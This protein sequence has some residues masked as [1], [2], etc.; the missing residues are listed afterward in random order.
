MNAEEI[1]SLRGL[2]ATVVLTGSVM[3][4]FSQC[5]EDMRAWCVT[6]GFINVEWLNF[7]AQ[8]VEVG[9]DQVIAH[10]AE[11]K[12]NFAL[13]IDAD[14]TFKPELLAQMLQSAFDTVPDSD[15]LG[16]Y[17]QLKHSPFLPVIDTGTGT[18]EAHFPG[19][20]ILSCIRTGGHCV[21][22]KT[23]AWEKFGPPW[24]RTRNTLRPL[25]V[26]KELDNFARV[27]NHGVNPFA[28]KDW[29]KLLDETTRTQGGVISG[30]GEDSGFC[31]ALLAAGG[32]LYVD[33][34]IVTGHIRKVNTSPDDLRDAMRA[35]SRLLAAS[36]G[37]KKS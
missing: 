30:V 22:V 14:A 35:K 10:A 9:R 17:A 19:E 4:E 25:D 20:G 5:R 7:S 32:K 36:V 24:F 3:E 33:T 16:A 23:S 28:G 31:D 27:H 6:N 37:V 21:L 13:M 29:T 18:W 11:N 34:N 26:M 12:Y 8:L 15:A 1:K 2:V